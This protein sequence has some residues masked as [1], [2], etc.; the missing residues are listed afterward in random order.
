MVDTRLCHANK[1]LI[2]RPFLS[3]KLTPCGLKWM[4]EWNPLEL[5]KIFLFDIIFFL[6]SSSTA[7]N[8]LLIFFDIC[9]PLVIPFASHHPFS[10]FHSIHVAFVCI[11]W[12]HSDFDILVRFYEI[13]FSHK[14]SRSIFFF[15]P[16]DLASLFCPLYVES[17]LSLQLTSNTITN[18]R[19]FSRA[20]PIHDSLAAVIVS[21]E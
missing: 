15:L 11:V 16:S 19:S 1:T 21:Q 17:F 20:L 14:F 13:S 7:I 10:M 12:D 18:A 6:H 5:V 4:N 2:G 9:L 3:N 8:L